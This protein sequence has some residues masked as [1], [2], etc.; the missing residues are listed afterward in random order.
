MQRRVHRAGGVAS[1]HA[2]KPARVVPVPWLDFP[3]A[4]GYR[5]QGW[6]CTRDPAEDS[7]VPAKARLVA[8][9]LALVGRLVTWLEGGG[10]SR[11]APWQRLMPAVRGVQG[12]CCSGGLSSGRVGVR[13]G[14]AGEWRCSIASQTLSNSRGSGLG[15]KPPAAA[16][17]AGDADGGLGTGRSMAGRLQQRCIVGLQ[18][19]E[20]GPLWRQSRGSCC[21]WHG[22]LGLDGHKNSVYLAILI[23]VRASLQASP[24]Y[25]P[26]MPT[27]ACPPNAG[28]EVEIGHR[29]WQRAFT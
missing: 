4:S 15:G 19:S 20:A 8:H 5:N 25:H 2:G 22:C 9:S 14:R 23:L 3:A 29:R 27:Q 13:S 28:G 6:I 21:R 10:C 24:R 11:S 1:S 16:A 7:A 12:R 18:S 17:H 26:G